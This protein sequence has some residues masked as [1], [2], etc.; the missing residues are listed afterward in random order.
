MDIS[1]WADTSITIW[2]SIR[3]IDQVCK[4]YIGKSLI[5]DVNEI[6]VAMTHDM[7]N[8]NEAKF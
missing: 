1:S 8:F 6:H 7:F 2:S 3:L 5:A 4:E